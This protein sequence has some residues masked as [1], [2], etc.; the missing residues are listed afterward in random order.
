MIND[1]NNDFID[2]N[3]DDDDIDTEKYDNNDGDDKTKIVTIITILHTNN[4]E[5]NADDANKS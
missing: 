3:I 5:D 2:G 4:G 1:D